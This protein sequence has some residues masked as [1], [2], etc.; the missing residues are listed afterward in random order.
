M[1]IKPKIRGFICTTAHP[2]GCAAHV[3]RQIN[4][5]KD[6]TSIQGAKKV[7]V[8]GASTGYGLAS[9]I[10]ASF[11]L[12]ADTIGVSYE[13]PAS[14]GRTA[15][16]GWYNTVA[17]ERAARAAGYIAESINGDAFSHEIKQETL[18]LVKEKLGKVDLI[19]YSV[20][21]PRRTHPDTGETFNSVL[22]P[23]GQSFSNKTV[24]TNTGVVSE[25]TLE[26]ATQEEIENTITVMGGEDWSLW[27]KA[28]EEADLLAEG[29]TTLAYSYIGPE[30]TE[31]IYRKGTIGQA[32]NDLEATAH[33]LTKDTFSVN[34]ALVTQSSSAIPVVPLYI[35]LL[36]KVMK[37]KGLHEGCIEQA[38]RLFETLYSGSTVE[39]DEEGRIR[40]DNWEMRDDVQQAVKASWSEITTENVSE[41]G[42]LEQY[43]LDFLQLFGFGFDEIDYEL[44]VNP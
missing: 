14:E 41:L 7:L 19:V 8:I 42:D 31:A 40:L 39:T 22:K 27:L 24:N 16:A 35:S 10:A 11:G 23:I 6:S 37:E 26:P 15:S 13:R 32:K 18:K 1:I 30:I 33:T 20:A 43:R 34:K 28:L 29:V 9:R 44:D 2:A 36:F 12:G 21:S 4:Y 25:I 17:F 5:I 3:N 38:Q